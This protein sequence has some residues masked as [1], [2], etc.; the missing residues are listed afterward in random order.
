MEM[1][2]PAKVGINYREDGDPRALYYWEY[3]KKYMEVK[4]KLSIGDMVPDDLDIMYVGNNTLLATSFDL[5]KVD[6]VKLGEEGHLMLPGK[7]AHIAFSRDIDTICGAL[8]DRGCRRTDHVY[9]LPARELLKLDFI[10]IYAPTP[11]TPLHVRV[12][13]ATHF[14]NPEARDIPY[15]SKV[16][17]TKLLQKYKIS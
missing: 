9:I 5:R 2:N 17:L 11:N 4:D 12:V 7:S 14:E 15:K 6:R 8:F 10:P 13:H 3:R 16:K 1:E